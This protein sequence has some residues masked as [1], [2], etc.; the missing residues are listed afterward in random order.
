MGLQDREYHKEHIWRLERSSKRRL[1]NFSM[2][3]DRMRWVPLIVASIT[4]AVLA[5]I[6]RDTFFR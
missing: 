5:V 1:F 4:C 3:S 2:S 6:Y